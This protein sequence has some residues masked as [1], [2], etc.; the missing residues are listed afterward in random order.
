MEKCVKF[1]VINT[2]NNML[3]KVNNI[4]KENNMKCSTDYMGINDE[5]E[6]EDFNEDVMELVVTTLKQGKKVCLVKTDREKRTDDIIGE[7][8][9]MDGRL[10]KVYS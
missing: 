8:K 2:Y 3:L 6:I 9:M 1:K 10:T 4:I 5:I 7:I